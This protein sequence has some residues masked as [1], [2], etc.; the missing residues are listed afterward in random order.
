MNTA[1]IDDIRHSM[2]HNLLRNVLIR[3]DYTGITNIDNWV[4]KFYDAAKEHN[5]NILHAF[6]LAQK[7]KAF[8]IDNS[9]DEEK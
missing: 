6:A 9:Q 3:L 2:K 4:E 1:S 7:W 8:S 5:G